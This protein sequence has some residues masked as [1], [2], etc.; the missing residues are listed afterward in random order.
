MSIVVNSP[1]KKILKS[2]ILPEIQVIKSKISKIEENEIESENVNDI[3]KMIAPNTK[4]YITTLNIKDQ[5][6]EI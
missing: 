1:I 3:L 5:N 2:T 6:K 4:K